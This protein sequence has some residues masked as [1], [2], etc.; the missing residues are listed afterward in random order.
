MY[1]RETLNDQEN[2][3]FYKIEELEKLP[4]LIKALLRD[5]VIRKRIAGNAYEMARKAQTWHERAKQL[6]GYFEKLW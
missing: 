6:V 5:E 3:C 1:L 4:D 2:I